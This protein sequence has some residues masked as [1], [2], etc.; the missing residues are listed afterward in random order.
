MLKVSKKAYRLIQF[1]TEQKQTKTKNSHGSLTNVKSSTLQ[2]GINMII[3]DWLWKE[4]KFCDNI[5]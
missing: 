1:K 5:R 4:K 2:K 3:Y